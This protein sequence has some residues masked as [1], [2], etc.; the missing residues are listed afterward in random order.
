MTNADLQN[1]L[2]LARIGLAAS[3]ERH[4]EEQVAAAAAS[5]VAVK[6]ELVARQQASAAPAEGA[7]A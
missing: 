7:Q 4:T 2:V 3:A 5:I 6:R 1:V